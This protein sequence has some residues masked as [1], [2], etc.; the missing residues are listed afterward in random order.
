M[1]NYLPLI[2]FLLLIFT[3]ACKP[4]TVAVVILDASYSITSDGKRSEATTRSTKTPND[5]IIAPRGGMQRM[6]N[7]MQ[8]VTTNL[9]APNA[10]TSVYFLAISGSLND[11]MLTSKPYHVEPVNINDLGFQK[12]YND[13]LLKAV[14]TNVI[15]RANRK[16]ERTC[17]LT[18]LQNAVNLVHAKGALEEGDS[19]RI[20]IL[21]DMVEDCTNSLAGVIKFTGR[22]SDPKSIDS[23]NKQ[24]DSLKFD[25]S[26]TDPRLKVYAIDVA[27]SSAPLEHQQLEMF[28]KK[29]FNKLG[30][31]NF[32][33]E[34]IVPGKL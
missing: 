19:L 14:Q 34:P 12:A 10:Y 23:I 1:R 4:K 13:S 33:F 18:T 21:S 32:R 15:E 8:E 30:Y 7:N 2:I 16:G 25:F 28:W 20:V 31:P 3:D 26:L 11:S 29:I 27:K 5:S 9:S 6:F 17:I 22:L 24:I